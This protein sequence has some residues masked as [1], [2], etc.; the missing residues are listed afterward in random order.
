MQISGRS[1]MGGRKGERAEQRLWVRNLLS[2]FQ[3]SQ[4]SSVAAAE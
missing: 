2:L 1:V 3:R 4:E